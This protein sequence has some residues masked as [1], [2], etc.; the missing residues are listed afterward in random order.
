MNFA[1]VES[2]V[3]KLRQDLAAGRLTD[4]QFK[5]RLRELMVQDEHGDWWMV[6]YESGQWHRHDGTDWVRADPPGHVVQ[7][8]PPPPTTLP[9]P[10]RQPVAGLVERVAL[11][12]KSRPFRGVV[13]L[14]VGLAVSCGA[15]AIAIEPAWDLFDEPMASICPGAIGLGGLILTIVLT[16]KVW[17]GE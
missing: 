10:T 1:E 2:E 7:K 14:L 17:R 9:K 4:E 3:A 5:A 16:R 8:P 11:I 6:G 13:V 12:A 15:G